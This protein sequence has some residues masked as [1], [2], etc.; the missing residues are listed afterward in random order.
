MHSRSN[1]HDKAKIRSPNVFKSP[2]GKAKIDRKPPAK[3]TKKILSKAESHFYDASDKDSLFI[4]LRD[5]P[6][7]RK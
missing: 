3:C 4:S 7:D 1:A 5:L 2:K 6:R